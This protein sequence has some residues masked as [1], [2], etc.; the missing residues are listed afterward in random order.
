M[1]DHPG[2]EYWKATNLQF[3]FPVGEIDLSWGDEESAKASVDFTLTAA[4]PEKK[5]V[6]ERSIGIK[7]SA[8]LWFALEC[9][10]DAQ[11]K[12]TCEALLRGTHLHWFPAHGEHAP[13]PEQSIRLTAADLAGAGRKE[14]LDDHRPH[15]DL[16]SVTWGQD[17]A[18]GR[19][20]GT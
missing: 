8:K 1:S 11:G 6:A 10:T 17:K 9:T 15:C 13:G 18:K 20:T 12:V 2:F 16:L 5:T 7:D 19:S 14:A 4:Q 3:P